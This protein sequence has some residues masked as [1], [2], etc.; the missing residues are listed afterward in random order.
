MS[1]TVPLSSA[2]AAVTTLK[3]EPGGYVCPMARLSIGRSAAA[4]SRCHAALTDVPFPDSSAGSYDGVLA[5]ARTRPVR[6]S[7]AATAPFLRP[8]PSNAARCTAGSMVVTTL[9]PGRRP[10]VRSSHQGKVASRWSVPERMPSS[11]PSSWDVP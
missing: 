7:T 2:A 11:A 5:S 4:L 1:V 8:S 9:P 6:G 10:R 3:T